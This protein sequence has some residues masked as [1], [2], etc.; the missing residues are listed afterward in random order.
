MSIKPLLPS[1]CS[2][3]SFSS[4]LRKTQTGF[5][6]IESSEQLCSYVFVIDSGLRSC[7]NM[8]KGAGEVVNHCLV[9]TS[10][11]GFIDPYA[12]S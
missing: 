12:H 5:Q 4:G 11:F 6:E 1:V 2:H 3:D 9:I 7:T 10:Y 8:G